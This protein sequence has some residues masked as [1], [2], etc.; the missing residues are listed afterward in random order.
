[1]F[2]PPAPF[3]GGRTYSAVNTDMILYVLYGEILD[4][5]VVCAAFHPPAYFLSYCMFHPPAP[6][7]G[8]R[9]YGAVNTDMILY[10]LYG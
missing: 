3:K 6:F 1:M 8:G 5:G 2:H 10:V 7:E 9:T 4:S